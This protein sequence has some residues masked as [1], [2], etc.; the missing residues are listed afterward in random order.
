[1]D[2]SCPSR[3]APAPAIALALSFAWNALPQEGEPLPPQLLSIS[4]QMSPLSEAFP[5]H[6]SP[7]TLLSWHPHPLSYFTFPLTPVT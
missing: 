7:R 4:D 1:M 5:D 2:G 6:P 3:R